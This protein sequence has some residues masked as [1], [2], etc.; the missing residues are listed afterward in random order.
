MKTVLI[1]ALLITQ[2]AFKCSATETSGNESPV[3]ST[4]LE[5]RITAADVNLQC[6]VNHNP[7]IPTN[8]PSTCL[9]RNPLD[10]L[11]ATIVREVK[12]DY[13]EKNNLNANDEEIREFQEYQ[14]RFMAKDRINRQ[15]KLAELEKKL[16]EAKLSSTEKEQTEKYRTTL[17]SLASHDKRRDE[18]NFK[19]TTDA[20]RGIAAPWIEG[21]KFNKSVYDKYGGTVGIT[22]F[23]PDPV[24]ATECLLQ[25]YEKQGKIVIHDENL[26]SAFWNRLSVPPRF[27]AKPEEIDFTPY[28]KKPLSEN[29]E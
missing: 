21:W 14:E 4:V 13:I 9:L 6:D 19:P 22:K 17:L 23:G 1:A 2:A 24:G 5:K 29:E 7:I 28:W 27:T 20:F 3:V 25:D 18:M 26:R 15:K 16:R 8:T 10:E 12:R 11:R